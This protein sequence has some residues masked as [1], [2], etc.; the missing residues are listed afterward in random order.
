MKL[1]NKCGISN[2]EWLR[3]WSWGTAADE[4]GAALKD[5]MAQ[6]AADVRSK[7][8]EVYKTHHQRAGN[9]GLGAVAFS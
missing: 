6:G 9:R 7:L 4:L 1:I 5:G 3:H 2:K 8:A